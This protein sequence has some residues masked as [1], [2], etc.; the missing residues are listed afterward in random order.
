M[1]GLLDG[2]R[3]LDLTRILAGPWATQM[4]ADFGADVLKIERP[5]TGD[6]TRSWGPPYLRD[7]HGQT[8]S[9]SAYFLAVN[10]GKRSL[11]MDIAQVEAQLLIRQLVA[12]ADVVVENYKVGTLA[13]YGLDYG[14]LS[15]INPRLIY[16]SIT[17]FGQDGPYAGRAGYDA[18]IQAMG[19]L[20]S[21]TGEPDIAGGAPT[22]VGVAVADLMCGMYAVSAILAAV[23]ERHRSG[24]GQY[25]DLAL[26]DTQVGWLANQ[27]MN[28]LVTRE[29][30]Q[31]RGNAHPNIV[32]Y[33]VFA[34]ADGHLMLAVGNDDQFQRLC[35]VIERPALASDERFATNAARV[36]NRDELV[37]QIAACLQTRRLDD[38]LAAFNAVGVP[39]GPINTLDRVFA[40]PQ[41]Q[42]RGMQFT[43]PH[44]LGIELPQVANPVK[45]SRSSLQYQLAPPLLGQHSVEVLRELGL[46]NQKIAELL[47][48]G[49]VRA[50]ENQE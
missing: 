21:I 29:S 10:R 24:R 32:P 3:V 49:I 39:C 12:K 25:I 13:R 34:V 11:A 44:P 35:N 20:M 19:G 38:W 22:K 2:L 42:H 9:E 48:R 30:P 36:K 45:F 1:S 28:Y 33:Q 4:L 26:L 7:S 46:D 14:S 47:N 15:T 6:D 5:G 41:V 27:A 31:R 37:A 40:D 16:C 17:G 23:Q 18:M 43:L 8:T 50:A